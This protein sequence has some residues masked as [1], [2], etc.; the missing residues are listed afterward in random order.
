MRGARE[1]HAKMKRTSEPFVFGIEEGGIES[2]LAARGFADVRDVGAKEL[3]ARYLRGD[4][5][6]RY[7]KP[8]WR[9]VHAAVA[10]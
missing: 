9:I 3:C 7:V 1:E 2:F 8:W 4:R 10:P 5:R 6:N